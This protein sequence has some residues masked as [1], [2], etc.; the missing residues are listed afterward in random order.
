MKHNYTDE[1]IQ[2]AIDAACETT[3]KSYF[4]DIGRSIIMTPTGFPKTW[5]EESPARLA[6]ACELLE[7]LPTPAASHDSQTAESDT[8]EAHAKFQA[9]L[10]SVW[11]GDSWTPKVGDVVRL[12]SG[13]P[14][15][16][17]AAFRLNGDVVCRWFDVANPRVKDFEEAT[18]EPATKEDAR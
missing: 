7:R 9:E 13:G 2:A 10:E 17:V 6:L 4:A 5:P 15:M 18:I 11:N 3:Q 16:T 12:K 1:Q 8:F 14:V